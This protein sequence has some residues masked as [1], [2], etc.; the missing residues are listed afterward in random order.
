MLLRRVIKLYPY[1][2]HILDG[3][4]SI[5]NMVLEALTSWRMVPAARLAN[6]LGL[7]RKTVQRHYRWMHEHI[8]LASEKPL[9]R[10]A[11]EIEV[12]ESYFSGGARV[13]QGRGT[14]LYLGC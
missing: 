9:G 7:N 11:G 5:R 10:L 12:D 6:D 2:W 14:G 3:T 1:L 8:A 4:Y 13:S